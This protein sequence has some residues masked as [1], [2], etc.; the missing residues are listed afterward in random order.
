MNFNLVDIIIIL[1]ILI[2]FAGGYKKGLIKQAVST[3]GS[4]ICVVAAFLF[5]NQLS[6]LLYKKCPFITIGLLK[7]YSSLNILLYELIAFFI[8]LMLFSLILWILIKISGIIEKLIE[9]TIL[10]KFPSKLGGGLLGALEMYIF[11]F[12][13]LLVLSLPLFSFSFN[14]EIND[15]LFARKILNNTILISNISKPLVKS[16][17]GVNDLIKSKDELGTKEFNCKSINLFK[18]NRIVTEE[19]LEYLKNNGKIADEC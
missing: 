17:E 13:A 11:C 3:F 19:S 8:L 2:G 4:I 1:F 15:S 10:L 14:E 9:G 16:V 7:N 5:K 6:I 18:K 12:I